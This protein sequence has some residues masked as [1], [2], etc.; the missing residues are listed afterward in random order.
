[1][2]LWKFVLIS[3]VTILICL[4]WIARPI[5]ERLTGPDT[6]LLDDQYFPLV[7]H[8][9]KTIVTDMPPLLAHHFFA[10]CYG[11]LIYTSPNPSLPT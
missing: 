1:L 5:D 3:V 11:L 4:Q 9:F 2:G 6:M 7:R 8:V 10:G